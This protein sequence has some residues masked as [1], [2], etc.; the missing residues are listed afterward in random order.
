MS[1]TFTDVGDAFS[2]QILFSEIAEGAGRPRSRS[3]DGRCAAHPHRPHGATQF[4]GRHYLSILA[5][6]I[7][8]KHSEALK[9]LNFSR[10]IRDKAIGRSN[11]DVFHPP[12]SCRHP[13]PTTMV[14][15]SHPS[16]KGTCPCLSI[17][18]EWNRSFWRRPS[19]R[20]PSAPPIS[21]PHAASTL[22]SARPSSDCWPP[23]PNQPQS[24]L[25]T[26]RRLPP[27]LTH[28]LLIQ[29]AFSP[30]ATGCLSESARAAWARSG[31]HS[32]RSR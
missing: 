29:A 23:T 18:V 13:Q 6:F 14:R 20:R 15:L 11:I 30:A 32:R 10:H 9:S 17:L 5:Q 12:K 28:R 16:T 22:S 25:Q 7:W 2:D 24:S 27:V 21:S 4:P 31:W 3:G 8:A 19:C 1:R 26:H